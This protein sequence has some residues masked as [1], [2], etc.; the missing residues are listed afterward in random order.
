MLNRL[1]ALA[2]GKEPASSPLAKLFK[3]WSDNQQDTANLL[4][5]YICRGE[6]AVEI[7]ALV[8]DQA[9]ILLERATSYWHRQSIK[10]LAENHRLASPGQWVRLGRVLALASSY[11]FPKPQSTQ[12]PNWLLAI[13][14]ARGLAHTEAEIW[15]PVFI[16][17]VL[18]EDEVPPTD[19]PRIAL[20]AFW[21]FLGLRG[22]ANSWKDDEP[23]TRYWT[24]YVCDHID[25]VPATLTS[26]PAVAQANS[27]RWLALHPEL[28]PPLA[29]TLAQL[30]AV[31]SK[32][33][34]N[35]AIELVLALPSPLRQQTLGSALDQ[36]KA[37]TL[38][39]LVNRIARL[40]AEG[41][42]VLADALGRDERHDQV[43]RPALELLDAA[44]TDNQAAHDAADPVNWHAQAAS[45]KVAAQGTD[46]APT[47]LE[48]P[49]LPTVQPGPS[50]DQV[51]P[52][53]EA[54][55]AREVA[56]ME[57][58]L[59]KH[60]DFHWFKNSLEAARRLDR[61][62]LRILVDVLNLKT[63]R[64]PSA[65]DGLPD[66]FIPILAQFPLAGLARLCVTRSHGEKRFDFWLLRRLAGP[67]HDLRAIAD[68]AAQAG[69]TEA[70]EKTAEWVFGHE[71]LRGRAA[72]NVWPF[73]AL[74]PAW[75]ERSLGMAPNTRSDY[76]RPYDLATALKI[77]GAFPVLPDRYL[78]ALA[79]FATAETKTSRRAA[80]EVI[81]HHPRACGLAAQA[82]GSTKQ[83][84]R[85]AAA[86]W[87]GRLGDPAAVDPL[88]EALA[89][90][91]R[92]PVQAA[93]LSALAALGQDI[94]RHLTPEAL[95]AT[96][97][98]GLR[99]KRPASL[100][101]FPMAA[102]PT[103]R[104]KDGSPSESGPSKDGGP[105]DP[106]IIE[107]WVVLA[108]KLK[109]PQGAGLIPI[110]VSL[111][112][113]PSREELGRF[114]LDAWIAHDTL[115]RP[116][117]EARELAA[118]EAPAEWRRAQDWAKRYPKEE[119]AIRG[120]RETQDQVF[121]R[122]RAAHAAELVGSAIADKGLLALTAGAP[123]HH[124][125]ATG[126]RFIKDFPERRAQIEALVTAAA[127]NPDPAAIQFV[128]A[129]ARK[130][131][132]ETVRLKAQA[133]AEQIAERSGWSLDDLA[134]RTIQT[135][136]FDDSGLLTLDYGP[137]QFTGRIAH[138]PKTGALAITLAN[139]DGKPIKALPKPGAAD[140]EALAREARK[141]LT[142][143]KKELKQV[144]ALQSS[145]LFEAMCLERIWPFP[146]W[147]EFFAGHP[148]MA[149][150]VSTLVW[151]ATGPDGGY[152]LFRPTA[153]GELLDAAD[154][155]A[156]IGQDARVGLAHLATVSPAEA[157]QWRASLEDYQIT[158]LFGQFEATTPEFQPDATVIAD[159]K[160]WLSDS[161]AIRGRATKR[162]YIR[163]PAEDG[164][165][166]DHYRKELPGA[167]IRVEIGFTGSYV[168]EE[169]LAA[170]VTELAFYSKDY[171][172]MPLGEVPPILLAE[173]YADYVF[174]A[175][176]GAFDPEW[177]KHSAF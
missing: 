125:L 67:D 177:E 132:Q 20:A 152:Q 16:E 38:P 11:G 8:E 53:L 129:I 120:A 92:E 32:Q 2:T 137:R 151:K 77:L 104:W 80:Q 111:L 86:A 107:W 1:R 17:A 97:A 73:F 173:S 105:V 167:G 171:R 6:R 78:A 5:D 3:G 82:L 96:A 142:T 68:V 145:R 62:M 28:L 159:R 114:V 175:E 134:D 22:T 89:K 83:E 69:V 45:C 119:W 74:N 115:R 72:Q 75:L 164:A 112:N 135:A 40:G 52:A 27:L 87:L 76:Q 9:M 116:D 71:G 79:G 25:L 66:G 140:E 121:E 166:F 18:A 48:L 149:Q 130:H 117:E 47:G 170:A 42:P 13:Q 57:A 24:E 39:N 65:L 153:E 160:G 106:Q 165:G 174:V 109:D 70:A 138:Q 54:A 51:L 162:G 60:P 14:M 4:A 61:P 15:E 91:K 103:C 157:E 56:K 12:A 101:W 43:I 163:G 147:Q 155:L 118:A 99:G 64:V 93:I 26:A 102:L 161:F 10:P 176:A 85:A 110:Y 139:P 50:A 131:K 35:A 168:P 81:G 58:N 156:L 126:Q 23:K 133:L 122:L 148:V 31:R 84:V 158:P 34:S 128:L 169:Q 172:S 55:A 44:S 30:T 21:E 59:L 41:R 154:D 141:Q 33:A 124:V 49:P 150:L 100:Q 19:Q 94:S 127:A 113:Q 143:S 136:G 46:A 7:T 90:E 144:A 37:A 63:D 29:P 88:Q 123:G 36:A 146:D 108:D 95:A 98:K